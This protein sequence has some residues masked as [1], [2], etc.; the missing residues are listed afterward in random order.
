MA[1]HSKPVTSKRLPRVTMAE[2]RLV[3]ANVNSV[4]CR[5]EEL[6]VYLTDTKPHIVLLNET[7]L[8]GIPL[9]RFTGYR[10]IAVRDRTQSKLCGGGVAILVSCEHYASDISPDIDDVAAVLLSAGAMKIA[11]VAYYCSPDCM[12]LD[13]DM[14][15]GYLRQYD[16]VIIAGDLNAK[17]QFYGSSRTDDRGEELFDLVESND[18]FCANDPHAKTRHVVATGYQEL[19][20]YVLV[21]KQLVGRV[22]DCYVGECIGSDHLPVDL[23]MQLESNI[24]TVPSREIRSFAKCDWDLFAETLRESELSYSHGTMNSQADID[25]RVCKIS[26]SIVSAIDLAC[27]KRKVKDFAFRLKPSTVSLIRLKRKL[28][29]KAQKFDNPTLRTAYERIRR[30]VTATI[31]TE[32]QQV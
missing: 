9:P 1:S 28:R 8:C 5:R 16:R 11:I 14:I 25:D 3:H 20:D 2:L 12:T 23:V 30:Q 10:V 19:V 4:L 31:R 26:D 17:H 15:E 32:R 24:S 13:H 21:S 6:Q 18:L 27:P 7:K 29:R 22:S